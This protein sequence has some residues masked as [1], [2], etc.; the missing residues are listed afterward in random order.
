[1]TGRPLIALDAQDRW[2][3]DQHKGGMAEIRALQSCSGFGGY[4]ST[5]RNLERSETRRKP[6]LSDGVN[7][8]PGGTA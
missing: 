2:R 4:Q 7:L 3:L 5:L 6:T 8:G 1:M